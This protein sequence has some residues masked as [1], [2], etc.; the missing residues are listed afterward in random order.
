MN[1]SFFK[2]ALL[3][4]LCAGTLHY[5][6]L[7]AENVDSLFA[8][9]KAAVNFD[10]MYPR[11]KVYLHLDNNAYFEGETLW[12]KAYVVRAST[13]RP[14]DLSRVLYVELL[15]GEGRV[16]QRKL[17]RIDSLGQ[18][19][20]EF[21]L[22]LPVR[23]GF[24]EVRAY[25]RE[26]TNWGEAACFSRVVPI[27]AKASD[28]EDLNVP[29]PD[30]ADQHP[31]SH[32]RPNSLDEPKKTL[33]DFYPESGNR[34]AGVEQRIAYRLTDGR[35][36][37][38]TDTLRLFAADGQ[39]IAAFE[40]EHEGM[41]T[42]TLPASFASGYV[43]VEGQQFALP[44]PDPEAQYA[45]TADVT[46]EGVTLVCSG[47]ANADG[48]LLGLGVFCREQASYFDTLHVYAGENVEMQLA[49]KAFHGGVSRI[50]LFD[51]T[52]KS[53]CRRLVWKAAPERSVNVAVRQNS[54]SYDAFSPIA[55]E[56]EL[57]DI[58]GQPVQTT[59]SLAVRDDGGE[60][61]RSENVG[62][63]AD[64]LL[65][66]EVKG[67]IHHPE[68]YFEGTDAAHRRALDLLLMVQ[69][70][71]A[72]SFETLCGVDTFVVE[73]PIE[74]K[75]TL[76]GRVFRN[77]DKRVPYPG[78]T[79]R[80]KM[81]NKEGAS[82]EGEAVTDEEGR[83]AMASNED[84]LGDWIAQISTRDD[85]DKR[86]WS[87][88]A[89]DRWFNPPA[90]IF[91]WQELNLEKPV[92]LAKVVEE[93]PEVDVETFFWKDTIPRVMSS[94]LG[95]AV[96]THHNA[97]RGFTGNRY[98]YRGG[99]EA[100]MRYA[101]VF[102]NIEMEVE[103]YK[104]AGG[105]PGYIYDF[106]A[107]LDDNASVRVGS[108]DY[109]VSTNA[110]IG[111][112][113]GIVDSSSDTESTSLNGVEEQMDDTYLTYKN[114]KVKLY[115]NNDDSIY[116]DVSTMMAEEVKSVAFIYGGAGGR[117]ID[118]SGLSDEWNLFIYEDPDLY[119]FATKRGVEKR[120]IT[121]YSRPISFFS[122][123]YNGLDLPADTDVRRTLYWNP[124][125]TTD[126]YGRATALFYG[127][128]RDGQQL[129]ISARGVTTDGRFVDYER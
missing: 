113:V 91:D 100:G 6:P 125:M 47:N 26:M 122:P 88:V 49:P 13:L 129:R 114:R 111:L 92:A 59:F 76:N 96:V 7:R 85:N 83:F 102:Y 72:N 3:L 45:L 64:L 112:T 65:A 29:R 36:V 93:S 2:K 4:L 63:A 128:S 8:R 31:L 23:A 66:S 104:D 77:N 46:E 62:A 119:R 52:G 117:H 82:L 109:L 56:M 86:K 103:R 18:A 55:M 106:L 43:E 42:F 74:E 69:G 120:R 81:Y 5:L 68:F 51:E 50:E 61:V 32:P 57:S 58:N 75:L 71:T 22:E 20:G 123:S 15:D 115:L 99:E 35:G 97:Y 30:V 17:L 12:F 110:S 40:S 94:T 16:Q 73:Q 67:Y 28:A 1:F 60:L 54:E 25:T 10:Y 53:L 116:S 39:L 11:E 44:E 95:E 33:L 79:L 108:G 80:I 87:R 126:A 90:R 34:V 9:F 41:G 127:N 14:T 124:N 101:D 19:N 98:T 38:L 105:S 21:Q 48:R 107:Y 89:L 27:F 118:A 37:P 84:F 121:G 70:W 78:L 24:Y